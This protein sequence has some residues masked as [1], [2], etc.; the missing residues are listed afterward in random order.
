VE[1][2]SGASNAKLTDELQWHPRSQN[3]ETGLRGRPHRM[4]AGHP[5]RPGSLPAWSNPGARP[6]ASVPLSRGAEAPLTHAQACGLEQI[7]DPRAQSSSLPH[8]R[9]SG[10]EIIC[11]EACQ[12]CCFAPAD[13]R[14]GSGSDALVA[15]TATIEN[16]R[17]RSSG[18]PLTFESRRL[19]AS[20]S[21]SPDFRSAVTRRCLARRDRRCAWSSSNER[22]ER[23]L[24]GVSLTSRATWTLRRLSGSRCFTRRR[25]SPPRRSVV[26]LALETS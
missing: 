14:S 1:S 10:H 18:R 6:C 13:G 2:L 11:H 3:V 9:S 24:L 20:G 15:P 17:R 16:S 5:L 8:S 25:T 19:R 12:R 21:A 22:E 4:I 23:Q 7:R 26:T